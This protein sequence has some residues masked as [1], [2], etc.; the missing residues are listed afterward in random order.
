[1]R[2]VKQTVRVI[3][4]SFIKS[5]VIRRNP[6]QP[7]NWTIQSNKLASQRFQMAQ[8]WFQERITRE[9]TMN[10]PIKKFTN[11]NNNRISS[12]HFD[13]A[14][15]VWTRQE[16]VYASARACSPSLLLC[17][18]VMQN[19]QTVTQF[20][21]AQFCKKKQTTI[22]CKHTH[23]IWIHQRNMEL[24]NEYY[25]C[26]MNIKLIQ[27]N[28]IG[29]LVRQFGFRRCT[30]RMQRRWRGQRRD[31]LGQKHNTA[32][33]YYYTFEMFLLLFKHH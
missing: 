23:L 3:C 1:M 13:L 10:V 15:Y 33:I 17:C 11:I 31:S 2:C 14:R 16:C 25:V 5:A 12:E 8:E 24:M 30:F 20:G 29:I 26:N 19:R 7:A 32:S 28:F 18:T 27:F 9:S 21:A 6:S 4:L 22:T